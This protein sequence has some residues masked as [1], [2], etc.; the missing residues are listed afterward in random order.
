MLCWLCYALYENAIREW[1]VS[2]V[3]CSGYLYFWPQTLLTESFKKVITDPACN[4][5]ILE[6]SLNDASTRAGMRVP[7]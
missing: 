1:F 7:R 2:P 3:M 6:L 4:M 5:Y